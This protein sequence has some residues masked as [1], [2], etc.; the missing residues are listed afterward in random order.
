MNYVSNKAAKDL[1]MLI[2][3]PEGGSIA[4]IFKPVDD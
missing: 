2:E 3:V 4:N 1:N